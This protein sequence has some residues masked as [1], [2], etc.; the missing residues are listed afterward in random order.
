ME[1]WKDMEVTMVLMNGK[2]FATLNHMFGIKNAVQWGI[3]RY[4]WTMLC[5]GSIADATFLPFEWINMAKGTLLILLQKKE[6]NGFSTEGKI[7]LLLDPLIL[8]R[9]RW[10]PLPWPSISYHL[11]TLPLARIIS[12]EREQIMTLMVLLLSQFWKVSA[13]FVTGAS[14]DFNLI[15]SDYLPLLCSETR[16]NVNPLYSFLRVNS[17]SMSYSRNYPHTGSGQLFHIQP[18]VNQKGEG[19]TTEAFLINVINVRNIFCRL[20]AI[21]GVFKWTASL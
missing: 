10:M 15:F 9:S 14:L 3:R 2:N 19:L 1:G 21:K 4:A 5:T 13:W 7:V 18:T 16:K 11:E 12:R 6:L 20:Q 17:L 8:A